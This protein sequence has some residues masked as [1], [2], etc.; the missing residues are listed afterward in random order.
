MLLTEVNPGLWDPF[1]A[2]REMREEMNR[3]FN[4]R[5]G[6]N[7]QYPPLNLWTGQNQAIVTAELPGV[8]AEELDISVDGRTLTLEG[9]RKRGEAKAEETLLAECPNG[10]FRRAVELPFQVD[11]NGIQAKY[12]KG[13]LEVTLPRAPE[14][15]PQKIQVVAA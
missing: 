11:S 3:L 6:L 1:D 14:D 8:N 5:E 4:E 13:I 9:S 10:T 15:R 7:H 12:S 2:I